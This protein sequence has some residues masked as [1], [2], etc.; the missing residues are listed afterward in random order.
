MTGKIN[1]YKDLIVW[2]QAM[3]LAVTTYSLTKAWQK[4]NCMG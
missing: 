4:R 2:Q 1:S 3:D